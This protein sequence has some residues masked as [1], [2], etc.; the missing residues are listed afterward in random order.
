MR[1]VTFSSQA[2]LSIL[3]YRQEGA[4]FEFSIAM[5]FI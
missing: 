2:W 3:A 1:S 4:S 5:A